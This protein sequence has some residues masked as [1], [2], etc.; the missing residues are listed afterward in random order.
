MFAYSILIVGGLLSLILIVPSLKSVE[1]IV[2]SSVYHL[3]MFVFL[4]LPFFIVFQHARKGTWTVVTQWVLLSVFTLGHGYFI[5][6]T[7]TSAPQEFGYVGLF[8][9]PLL[10]ALVTLPLLLLL[11]VFRKGSESQS[12]ES[13]TVDQETNVIQ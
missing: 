4:V 5:Y 11:R 6:T 8:F 13:G 10:E 7:Y 9:V 1:G 2:F 12:N 3:L